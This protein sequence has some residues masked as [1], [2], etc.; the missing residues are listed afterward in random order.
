MAEAEEVK[1]GE[2]A[3]EAFLAMHVTDGVEVDQRSDAGHDHNHHG[4]ERIK[5][6]APVDLEISDRHPRSDDSFVYLDRVVQQAEET[7]CRDH[8]GESDH[9]CR[10]TAN[11]RF[12]F[13]LLAEQAV[14]DGT[15]QR[16]ERYEPE[17]VVH[18]KLL[19][20]QSP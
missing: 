8:K 13:D 3:V 6:E 16:K 14:D 4:R 12:I 9:G 7:T 15:H 19:R 20:A 10:E 11:H 18:L 1:V 2:E 5:K 17:I